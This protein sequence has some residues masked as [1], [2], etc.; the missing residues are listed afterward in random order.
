MHS[1]APCSDIF[2][3]ESGKALT[4]REVKSA[5]EWKEL[6][7]WK[8]WKFPLINIGDSL[9]GRKWLHT[10]SPVAAYS[11][12]CV[13]CL[14][15]WWV[16]RQPT[17]CAVLKSTL[18]VA[19]KGNYASCLHSLARSFHSDN[20]GITAKLRWFTFC[21]FDCVCSHS[22]MPVVSSCTALRWMSRWQ[23]AGGGGSCFGFIQRRAWELVTL[24]VQTQ[25]APPRA[26]SNYLKY[27]VCGRALCLC[28]SP[29]LLH[30][31]RHLQGWSSWV[32]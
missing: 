24:S 11:L 26:K 28:F 17:V 9:K 13:W 27:F 8:W 14:D 1:N 7:R 21:A 23:M 20:W 18:V 22:F 12:Y 31:Q 29:H 6:F 32:K 3:V 16:N 19:V 4:E 5:L 2:P 30:S 10:C 15:S 25:H